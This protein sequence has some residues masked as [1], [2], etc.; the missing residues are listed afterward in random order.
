MSTINSYG[1]PQP[2]TRVL[3][4]SENLTPLVALG[5]GAVG[6]C[7][8]LIIGVL[9]FVPKGGV[10]EPLVD[11]PVL[12]MKLGLEASEFFTG[13]LVQVGMDCR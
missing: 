12:G 13:G 11:L 2:L 8:L 4:V 10:V 3:G 7:I 6:G 1:I 5:L 9:L